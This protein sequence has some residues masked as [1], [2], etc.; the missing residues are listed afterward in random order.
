MIAEFTAFEALIPESMFDAD[1]ERWQSSR[2]SWWAGK[3]RK[4]SYDYTAYHYDYIYQWIED[5]M[6]NYDSVM[7]DISD[8]YGK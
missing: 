2:D 3:G 1:L 7:R 5:R 8:Y 6:N 4:D